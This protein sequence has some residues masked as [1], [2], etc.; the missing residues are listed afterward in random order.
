MAGVKDKLEHNFRPLAWH[1]S[2]SLAVGF[3]FD[4]WRTRA[5]YTI[6]RDES[7]SSNWRSASAH[8]LFAAGYLAFAI[9]RVVKIG[10]ESTCEALAT[11]SCFNNFIA[12]FTL[13]VYVYSSKWPSVLQ[14]IV[15]ITI[16]VT[17]SADACIAT[18]GFTGSWQTFIDIPAS[19]AVTLVIGLFFKDTTLADTTPLILSPL[20]FISVA[21]DSL[22]V[23]SW[24]TLL[25]CYSIVFIALLAI[26]IL[27]KAKVH[28][29]L[30]FTIL[31]TVGREL[32]LADVR[33]P[34]P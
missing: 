12:L 3:T 21:N 20:L 9:F 26:A 8:L 4:A 10:S 1:D 16:A 29:L 19:A 22:S 6:A 15:L 32:V 17:G 11:A 31:L 13:A 28:F 18:N 7:R 14:A 27:N 5:A 24:A 2:Q 23:D 30:L 33:N 34:D 25:V